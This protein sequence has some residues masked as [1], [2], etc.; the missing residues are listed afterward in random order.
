MTSP[1]TARLEVLNTDILDI[2]CSMVYELEDPASLE[3]LSRTDKHMR[4]LAIPHLFKTLNMVFHGDRPWERGSLRMKTWDANFARFVRTCNISF[5]YEYQQPHGV[6]VPELPAQ[7]AGIVTSLTRVNRITCSIDESEE[8]HFEE[9]FRSLK[10]QIPSVKS[11][12]GPS[13]HILVHLCPNLER[14]S[15]FGRYRRTNPAFPMIVNHRKLHGSEKIR[16][17]EM[18]HAWSVDDIKVL[19][20]AVPNVSTLVLDGCIANYSTDIY[21]FLPALAEF[22]ALKFLGIMDLRALNVGFHPPGC[23]N[24]YRGPGGRELRERVSRQ[25]KDLREAVTAAA[26]S[27]CKH[28]EEVWIGS[29][30]KARVERQDGAVKDIEY[31]SV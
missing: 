9:G 15:S 21:Q 23:G 8:A 3:Q 7:L 22:R 18:N 2:I 16:Y 1:S 4:A 28:L 31:F 13:S 26:F 20:E 6:F 29:G 11:I 12:L 19:H 5:A 17:L 25:A 24:A 30:S 14:I 27:A 10:K